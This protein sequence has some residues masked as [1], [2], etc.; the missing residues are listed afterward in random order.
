MGMR[1]YYTDREGLIETDDYVVERVWEESCYI[2]ESDSGESNF[3]GSPN[4][5]GIMQALSCIISTTHGLG[6]TVRER[7][8][9]SCQICAELSLIFFFFYHLLAGWPSTYFLHRIFPVGMECHLF[10]LYS[11]KFELML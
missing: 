4:L 7:M 1:H 5:S 10:T 11:G 6:T 3:G 2:G 9:C 8:M